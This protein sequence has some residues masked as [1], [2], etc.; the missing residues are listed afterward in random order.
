MALSSTRPLWA[1]DQ[2]VLLPIILG[3]PSAIFT[4][5]FRLFSSLVEELVRTRRLPRS[6]GRVQ[7]TP[8]WRE[9]EDS[10]SLHKLHLTTPINQSRSNSAQSLHV[11]AAH[12]CVRQKAE[13]GSFFLCVVDLL[14]DLETELTLC[15]QRKS[16]PVVL[17]FSHVDRSS[18]L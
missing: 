5:L 8:H 14:E 11:V 9:R 2:C 10:K 3:S 16:F 7:T 13:T 12:I 1:G 4:S 17:S 6:F 18:E 15:Q